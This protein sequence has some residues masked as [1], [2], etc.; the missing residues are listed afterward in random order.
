[1]LFHPEGMYSDL[2]ESL[3]QEEVVEDDLM[4]VNEDGIPIYHR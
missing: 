2:S 3:L 4:A 1:M